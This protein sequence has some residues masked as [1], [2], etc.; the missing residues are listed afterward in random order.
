[1]SLARES[2]EF[3]EKNK[4]I[5]AHPAPLADHVRGRQFSIDAED[6]AIVA[7]DQ[8]ALHRSLKGRHMQMIAMWVQELY[9]RQEASY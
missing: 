9:A 6:A 1:M 7:Q 5:D 2:A 8:N 3:T 4:H